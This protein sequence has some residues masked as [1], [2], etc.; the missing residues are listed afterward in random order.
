ME[1]M[2]GQTDLK[3]KF[4]VAL[5]ATESKYIPKVYCQVFEDNDSKLEIAKRAKIT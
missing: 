1:K 5:S 4:E 3:V 2:S